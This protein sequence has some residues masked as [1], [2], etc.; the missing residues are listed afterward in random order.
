MREL[1]SDGILSRPYLGIFFIPDS[2]GN[3]FKKI[4]TTQSQKNQLPGKADPNMLDMNYANLKEAYSPIQKARWSSATDYISRKSRPSTRESN[5]AGR[6]YG[7]H[8]ANTGKYIV[9]LP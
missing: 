5:L 3:G 4:R 8:E 1:S 6:A 2:L 9:P 7:R